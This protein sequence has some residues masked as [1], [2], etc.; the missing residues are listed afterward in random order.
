MRNRLISLLRWSE[1][2]T[3]TDMVYLASGGFWSLIGQATST[4]GTFILAIAVGHFFPT[5]A[6]GEYKYVL[7]VVALLSVFSLNSLSGAVFQSVAHGYDGALQDGFRRNLLWSSLIFIA[8]CGLAGY[9]FYF[10]NVTLAIGIL[11]GGCAAPFFASSNLADSFLTAK[12]DFKRQTLYL[13]VFAT[14]IPSAALI[15]TVII[16]Q[17][18]LVLAIVYFITNTTTTYVAYRMTLATYRPDPLKTDSSM[19]SY[20]KHLSVIGILGTIA[21]NID[22]V[23]LF[24]FI[25]PI[26]LAF[27]NF[28]IAIPDQTKGPLKTFNS[29]VQARFAERA[30]SQIRSTMARKVALLASGIGG[31]VIIY[32]IFAPYIYHL[33]FPTYATAAYLSQLYALSLLSYAL[34]PASSYLSIRKRIREQYIG[35]VLSYV[36]QIG[37]LI[38]G[39]LAGGLM[40]VI[41]A[42]IISRFFGSA[43]LYILYMID[44]R[45]STATDL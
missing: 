21:A 36:I 35:N 8:T 5:A 39:V 40:G 6:Y 3:G 20:G 4:I 45:R 28:A 10:Q 37:A 16:S 18:A 14:A 23:L 12:K 1:Q 9:Y 11:V 38:V 44:V 19:L 31:F 2:Y 41:W 26:Q 22:Q 24:H 34:A 32:I 42:R 27:Y 43:L 29:M 13:G 7:S 15:A 33:F 25:G 30:D 17:S